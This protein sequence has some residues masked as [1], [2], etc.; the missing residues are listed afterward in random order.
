MCLI[1]YHARNS[2]LVG[3]LKS[4][5]CKG[6]AKTKQIGSKQNNIGSHKFCQQFFFFK[7]KHFVAFCFALF[8][9]HFN[10]LVL[11]IYVKL[12]CLFSLLACSLFLTSD[13]VLSFTHSIK[14]KGIL[15]ADLIYF[16]SCVC[17]WKFQHCLVVNS[18]FFFLPLVLSHLNIC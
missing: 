1:T 7:T 18:N 16:D 8:S 13:S 15:F 11:Q 10:R 2:V 3:R 5:I 17:V 6:K 9:E 12:L 4:L 14:S